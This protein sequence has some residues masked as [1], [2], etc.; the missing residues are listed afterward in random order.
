MFLKEGIE[1]AISKMTDKLLAEIDANPLMERPPIA[2]ITA[3]ASARVAGRLLAREGAVAD[4]KFEA[5]LGR[6]HFEMT[7]AARAAQGKGTGK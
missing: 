3:F 7:E 6:L 2:F 5:A 1:E 4:G